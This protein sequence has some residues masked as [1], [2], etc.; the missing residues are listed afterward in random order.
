MASVSSSQSLPK[1]LTH[2]SNVYFE[3]VDGHIAFNN[4]VT[5]L[6]SKFPKY[7]DML[8]FLSNCCLSKALVIQPSAVYNKYLS[9]LWYS[10]EVVA[11][12]ITFSLSNFEKPLSF[13][14]DIFASVVGLEY[15]KEYVSL[16][17]HEAMKDAIATLGL[18]DDKE[19]EM[20]S[21]E[22][23]HSFPLRLRFFSPT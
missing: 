19:P 12:T 21:K 7:K 6:E 23:A 18:S 22:V 16:P 17:D 20:T 2:P 4:G 14:R 9:E 8:Q 15:S 3:L 10:T 5:L 11:N 1:T 13:N